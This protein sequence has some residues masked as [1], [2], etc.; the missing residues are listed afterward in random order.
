MVR[1]VTTRLNRRT[2]PSDH[3][4]LIETPFETTRRVASTVDAEAIAA[5][6]TCKRPPLG[7]GGPDECTFLESSPSVDDGQFGRITLEFLS[8]QVA[9]VHATIAQRFR[10]GAV[11]GPSL[12]LGVQLTLRPTAPVE[13]RV[14]ER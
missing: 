12:D 2:R 13:L 4:R 6:R 1:L 7:A 10:I 14:R 9:L 8:D 11:P 5:V 3:I